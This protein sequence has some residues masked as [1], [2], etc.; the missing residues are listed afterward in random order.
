MRRALFHHRP[1]AVKIALLVAL[2]GAIALV[3][4]SYALWGMHRMDQQYRALIASQLR[5]APHLA[6]AA[7]LL[8]E[9]DRLVHTALFDPDTARQQTAA[10]QLRAV[11][12]AF[13]NDLSALQQSLLTSQGRIDALAVKADALFEHTLGAA[14]AAA[15]AQNEDAQRIIR[16]RLEPAMQALRDELEALRNRAQA[17]YEA[18][19]NALNIATDR[20]I[21]A[22]TIAVASGLALV[23]ALSAYVAMTQIS[24]PVVHLARIMQR[25]TARDYED[26]IPGTHRRDEVGKMARALQV[27]KDSMQREDRLAM[28]VAAS[29][30]ARRLS[31]QLI[32]LANAIPGAVFQLSLRSDGWCRL[33]FVSNK[34]ADLPGIAP[35][36]LRCTDGPVARVYEA[37]RELQD[38]ARE[39]FIAS[40]RNLSPVD[41]DV[42]I[43]GPQGLRWL[44]TLASA[45]RMG[46]GSVLFSGVWLDVTDRRREAHALREAKDLAEQAAQDRAHF[47][48]VMSHEIRTPLN[49]ILGLTQL[50][51]KEPLSDAQHDRVNQMQRAGE[52]LLGIVNDIL[53]FSKIDGGHLQ[54]EARRF[55]LDRLVADVVDLCAPKALRKGLSLHV[56]IGGAVPAHVVGDPQRI[57]QILINYVH[58]SIKFTHRGDIV[59]R[60]DVVS[61]DESGVMLRGEV[62]DTGIGLTDSQ[63]GRLFQPFQQADTSITRRFGG[64]G[65][66]LVIS[67]QLAQLMQGE[68]G[69]QS[70]PDEG[71][72][73]WFTARVLQAPDD[74]LMGDA[75]DGNTGE[76][77]QLARRNSAPA[78]DTARPRVLVVDDNPVNLLVARGLLE[79]AGVDVGTATDGAH[80]LEVLASATPATYAAVL[81]DIQMPV[82]DGLRATRTLRAQPQWSQLPIIAMTANAT[83]T[84]I[85]AAYAAGMNDYLTK[86]LLEEDLRRTL[87]RWLALAEAR[88]DATPGPSLLTELRRD[89]GAHAAVGERPAFD[90]QAL[91]ELARLFDPPSLRALIDHFMR[92]CD[93]RVAVIHAAVQDQNWDVVHRE[94]H[95]LGGSV[96]S[97]GL[98]RLDDV[99]HALETAAMAQDAQATV[100]LLAA[101]DAAVSE[102]RMHLH[103]LSN[104]MNDPTGEAAS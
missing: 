8:S 19:A 20:A 1:L 36:V 7:L 96:G 97:F 15:L 78:P 84:H 9:S 53:D 13:R 73:F 83:P 4:M 57:A 58:N 52:H 63:I 66:G 29:A 72:T 26:T 60:L 101:L 54:L 3:V 33:L 70:S 74:A 67:R 80:A 12:A 104:V 93:R 61:A 25:L 102:G 79:H 103:A 18:A 76:H 6:S 48:A 44:R 98:L 42:E 21:W 68:A 11:Q 28:E 2:M 40:F 31:E 91:E 32:D 16:D 14:E 71:S 35:H 37:A 64:T 75:E 23:L 100:T 46:D 10:Q 88:A 87:G 59:I 41:F 50:A 34:A 22:T 86:P 56:E 45:R 81:M 92:N 94:A 77:P 82:M 38:N 85:E 55:E 90:T 17:D 65:L 5:T 47:L 69:V 39:S 89:S 62:R 30:E 49:A 95:A 99:L 43:D 51:L 27:F 24:R